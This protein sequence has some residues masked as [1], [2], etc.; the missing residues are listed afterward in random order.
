MSLICTSRSLPLLWH[1]LTCVCAYSLSLSLH[2]RCV[3]VCRRESAV[4]KNIFFIF[5]FYY[6][7]HQ[8]NFLSSPAF[9]MSRLVAFF[10]V[11]V[12]DVCAECHV[13]KMRVR[14][15]IS[16]NGNNNNKCNHNSHRQT[17][18]CTVRDFMKCECVMLTN[19]HL[20]MFANGLIELIF[21]LGEKQNKSFW[22]KSFLDALID[23]AVAARVHPKDLIFVLKIYWAQ[24]QVYQLIS[25]G[26][27]DSPIRPSIECG[28]LF[29]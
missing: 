25:I 19:K 7:H 10:P 13:V 5:T 1:R 12:R 6:Y 3:F 21:L 2:R 9:A 4:Y 18:R 15:K 26:K 17:V 22:R 16:P 8:C 23:N 29:S 27:S 20:K 28:N 24:R 14:K 11:L